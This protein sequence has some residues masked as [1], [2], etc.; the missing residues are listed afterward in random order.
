YAPSTSSDPASASPSSAADLPKDSKDTEQETKFGYTNGKIQ[1]KYGHLHGNV[2]LV[3][4]ERVPEAGLGISLAGNRDRDKNSTFVLSVK[5]QCPLTVRAG[6]ELL[7]VN[8]RVLVGHPHIVASSIIRQCCD[9]GKGLE[10]V[11]CRR[12]G[13]MVR[14]FLRIS[15][16]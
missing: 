16:D 11:L 3:S 14:A 9:Q 13:S 2:M 10:I 8:G 1:R 6:D 5:V 4:C 15:H 12:D 7:E